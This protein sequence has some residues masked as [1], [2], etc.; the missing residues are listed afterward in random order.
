M[1]YFFFKTSWLKSRQ[2]VLEYPSRNTAKFTEKSRY[3]LCWALENA[4]QPAAHVSTLYLLSA[5]TGVH[6]VLFLHQLAERAESPPR[7]FC[8]HV[9]LH[10]HKPHTRAHQVGAC[11]PVYMAVFGTGL[12][13]HH[14]LG[15]DGVGCELWIQHLRYQTR[16]PFCA[17]FQA[18]EPCGCNFK[19][20]SLVQ[21]PCYEHHIP[22]TLVTAHCGLA[23]VHA[24]SIKSTNA[25][26]SFQLVSGESIPMHLAWERK[27]CRAAAELHLAS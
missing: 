14:K 2:A 20:S 22:Q 6:R 15:C 3:L 17:V 9:F 19:G 26:H 16:A 5:P 4:H 25:W 1:N 27:D 11:L 7:H 12:A 8:E 23:C 21:T 18:A 13:Y 24:N 10:K